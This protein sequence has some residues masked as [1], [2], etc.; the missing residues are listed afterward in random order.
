M[1]IS[2]VKSA[3]ASAAPCTSLSV[4]VIS[5]YVPSGH[6]VPAAVSAGQL[7]LLPGGRPNARRSSARSGS[8]GPATTASGH[9][10]PA[11][12][13]P[14][15]RHSTHPRL[16]VPNQPIA[17]GGGGGA[18]HQSSSSAGGSRSSSAP[19][20]QRVS[21]Q[22]S[23]HGHHRI[24]PSSSGALVEHSFGASACSSLHS[25]HYHDEHSFISPCVKYSLFFFNL[26]FWVCFTFFL[27]YQQAN[28]FDIF[29]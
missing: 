15:T 7:P 4:G 10:V 2:V 29:W 8:S 17:G 3:N 21:G 24:K 19:N 25:C 22:S 14:S 20:A 11:G 26:L 6:R 28:W 23:H 27:T 16:Y 12:P 5:S 18:N 9:G 13:P 1:V